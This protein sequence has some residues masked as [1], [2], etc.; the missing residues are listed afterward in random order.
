MKKIKTRDRILNSSLQLF[1][2]LGEPN[3]TT[4]L[5]S[6]ELDISPGNLYYHFKSKG[7]IVE[8]LFERFEADML[9]LLAVP[10]DAEVPLDQFSFFL[11]L[12]FEAVARY[13]FMY[14]DLVNVLSRYE[15]L[16]VR[17]RRI[18]KKKT[19]AFESLCT[20]FKRQGLMAIGPAELSALC[21]QLTLTVCYWSS[22]DTLSH[23]D[24]REFVDP[25]KGVY[26]ILHLIL[27]HLTEEHKEEVLLISETYL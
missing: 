11:H 20:S 27:P 6:D 4:L 26:Q 25:G 10:G 14:Q 23:L 19:L 12:L 7:D 22:F 15:Q 13:R 18:L 21:Q 16:Q 5:I 9:D 8:E 24:D 1:N 17:F 2:S 3:V